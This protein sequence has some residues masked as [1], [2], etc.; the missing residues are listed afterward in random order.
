MAWIIEFWKSRKLHVCLEAAQ[1]LTCTVSSLLNHWVWVYDIFVAKQLHHLVKELEFL[2]LPSGNNM[3]KSSLSLVPSFKHRSHSLD[4]DKNGWRSPLNL[5][6][7]FQ[8]LS[9]IGLQ[10]LDPVLTLLG[11][12]Q[13]ALAG[14]ELGDLRVDLLV[15]R[16]ALQH[17]L[18]VSAAP[19][20]QQRLGLPV[21]PDLLGI[22]RQPLST[23]EGYKGEIRLNPGFIIS[24]L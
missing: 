8:K 24:H 14:Q 22:F 12:A 21:A 15:D 17:L 18:D 19:D 3:K 23:W 11:R 7:A 13:E 4:T 9:E 16:R 5:L 20:V 10:T 1:P 6:S 2:S